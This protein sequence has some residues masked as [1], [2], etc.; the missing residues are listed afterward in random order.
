MDR[1]HI[2]DNNLKKETFVFDIFINSP[3][4]LLFVKDRQTKQNYLMARE[5]NADPFDVT[6]RQLFLVPYGQYDNVELQ[7]EKISQ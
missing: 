2:I 6:K 5:K 4:N 7:I 3:Y 1:V